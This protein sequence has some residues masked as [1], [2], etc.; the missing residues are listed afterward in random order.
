[1]ESNLRYIYQLSLSDGTVLIN[2]CDGLFSVKS[3]DDKD[4][5]VLINSAVLIKVIE[6]PQIDAQPV[7][8]NQLHEVELVQNDAQVDQVILEN[9]LADMNQ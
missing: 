7:V 2:E 8:D 1:M 5:K 9:N 6:A 4:D 3:Q